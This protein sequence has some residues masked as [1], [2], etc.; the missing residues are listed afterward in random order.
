MALVA[1]VA[2]VAVVALPVSAA[3]MVRA[4]K[5][6]LLSRRTAVLAVFAVAKARS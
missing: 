2:L 6:P 1:L 4:V 5:S 3:V